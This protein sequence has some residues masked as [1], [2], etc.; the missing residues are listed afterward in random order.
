MTGFHLKR[1]KSKRAI[2]AAWCDAEE[3]IEWRKVWRSDVTPTVVKVTE[4]S[5][6]L[7]ED[8]F[9]GIYT[10]KY[11]AN[12]KTNKILHIGKKL[13]ISLTFEND[14]GIFGKVT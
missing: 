9:F 8:F 12:N 3:K 13:E 6:C 10:N 2:A 1:E 11:K 7:E 14:A 5:I 4:E